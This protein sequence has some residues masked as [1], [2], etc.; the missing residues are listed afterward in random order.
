VTTRR[1]L[2]QSGAGAV[3]AFAFGG[4]S[5]GAANAPGIT[6]TEIRIGQTMPYSGP[7]SAYGVEGKADAAYFRMI[8]E[9]GGV[10]GRKINLISLDDGYSPPKT[11]EQ[12]RRL[13][14]QE[15]VAFIFNSLGTPTNAAIR[16]Y[17]ND[18]RVPQLFIAS[19]AV[20]F[21]D[22]Q[23]FP[24]TMGFIPNFRA[25]ARIYARHIVATKPEAKIGVLYQNDSFGKD[26][27]IGLKDALGADRGAKV[28]KEVSFEIY[29][30]TVD[31]QIATL[32]GSGADVLLIA[33]TDKFA[34]QAIR[35]AFDIDRTPA[36]YLAYPSRSVVAVMKPAG[37][38]KS[39]GV[40]SANFA[41]DPTDP[42]WKDDPGMKEWQAFGAKYLSKTDL[43]D[44]NAAA[45]FTYAAILIPVLKQCGAD[46]SR[47]N[48][49][50]QAA[51]LKGIELPLFLP[52]VKV[53]TSP[54]IR[55]MQL[56]TFNGESWELFG[57]ILDA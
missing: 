48:I 26:Y 47:E 31:S 45:G 12:I 21:S 20:M 5:A 34:A 52:G 10:N 57:E 55:Q 53:N 3:A 8:N 30:P 19:G 39:K 32:Q 38:E 22:P 13:V 56:A 18:N 24:W 6:D 49:M 44:A 4:R 25:E 15:R 9:M 33:A 40:I 17:L 36:R 42:H 35:R 2:L 1:S 37:L 51:N 29:E 14:E 16:Q 28:I 41:K 27:L 50:R 43:I 23:R 46:L 54:T 11:V 7:A